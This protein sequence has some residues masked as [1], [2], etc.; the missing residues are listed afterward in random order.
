MKLRDLV[1]YAPARAAEAA[2]GILPSGL[3]ASGARYSAIGAG[4]LDGL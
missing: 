3:A 4:R 2:L 1:E